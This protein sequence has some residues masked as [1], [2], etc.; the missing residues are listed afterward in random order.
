MTANGNNGNSNGGRSCPQGVETR[1]RVENLI[2]DYHELKGTVK[3]MDKRL[4]DTENCVRALS[5][6]IA[7]WAAVG[8]I[9]GGLAIQ[10]FTKY[11]LGW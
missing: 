11:V 10:A 2:A 5:Q 6:R 9:G 4:A 1:V 8:M 3:D 7:M